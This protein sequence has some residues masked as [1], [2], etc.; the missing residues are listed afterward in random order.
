M[1]ITARSLTRKEVRTLKEKGI[2]FAS[3][4]KAGQ[5]AVQAG[6]DTT[7]ELAYHEQ[8]E[9]LDDMKYSDCLELFKKTVELT[10]GVA[11]Q[12]KN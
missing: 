4:D 10:F 6:V 1:A 12:E 7:L 11:E 9:E 3:L 8:I 5:E 2:N